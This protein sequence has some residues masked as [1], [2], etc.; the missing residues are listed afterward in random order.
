MKSDKIN[1]FYNPDR[2]Q[3]ADLLKGFAV[4]FMIQVHLT[5]NFLINSHY[6][7]IFSRISFFLGGTP[8]APVFMI[9]MGYFISLKKDF[10]HYLEKGIILFLGGI[11][12]NIGLN[13]SFLINYFQ[14]KIIDEDPLRFILG[15]D[16]LPF[17]GIS[18]IL[19]GLLR[20][21]FLEKYYL[22]SILAI[23]VTIVSDF[24]NS[25]LIPLKNVTEFSNSLK[26]VFSFIYGCSEWSYFPIIP[27]LFYPSMGF[28][29][30][31]ISD[32]LTRNIKRWLLIIS[33]FVLVFF[34]K[35]TYNQIIVFENYYHHGLLVAI[36][37]LSFVITWSWILYEIDNRFAKNLFLILIK[38]IGKN[39]TYIYV[40]QWL[41][42]G[43]LTFFL[44]N[45]QNEYQ[46]LVWFFI[47]LL[48]S[49]LLT[50]FFVQYRIKKSLIRINE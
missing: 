11:L 2:N 12:L 9:V 42:I 5:E 44:F 1:L 41:I 4:L 22:Y 30:R 48:S 40:F 49:S 17:A 21:I 35:E 46:V 33:I 28:S 18:L 13:L 6:D 3:V 20:K 23:I 34:S 29:L 14:N 10:I 8:A 38:W 31:L 36:W 15:A 26:F 37:N 24:L 7:K 45:S 43:N 39:V 50:Y 47:V 27:W 25:D 19:L 32:R 16:I